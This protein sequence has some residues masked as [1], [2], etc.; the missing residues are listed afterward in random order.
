MA[1]VIIAIIVFLFSGAFALVMGQTPAGVKPTVVVGDV[2]TV[3]DKKFV[4]NWKTGPVDITT[5]DKTSF[6]KVSAESPNLATATPGAFTDIGVGDKLT[7]SGIMD[8]DGKTLP[9]RSVYFITKADIAAKNA[10]ESAEWQRRGITGKVTAV[11]AQTNQ[12]TLETRTLTGASNVVVTPKEGV[13]FFRYAP[14]SIRFDEAVASSLADTKVGDMVRALGDKSSDGL[15]FAAE[16]VVAGAFQTI[17]GTVKSIDT[18]KNEVII[19][20]LQTNKDVT[21]VISETSVLKRFPAEQAEMLARFQMMGAVG[22][23]ARPVG[24]PGQ[25]GQG[26]GARGTQPPAANPGGN[27]GGQGRP[28]MGGGRGPGGVED[29]LERSPNISAADLKVGDIIALSSTKTADVARI[30]AIKLF[31]G[32]EPFLRAAQATSGRGGRGGQGGV[33]GGFSIPGLDGIGF[34]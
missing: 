17:A 20:N 1:Q 3:G 11:N 10:K 14:D 22:G 19:K 9:A 28:G 26:G 12:M 24:Q 8:A 32:V 2:V 6:K 5:N 16:Q 23:G 18:A 7:V 13:K 29:M 21:I 27:P 25:G 31:A 15:S 34:P 30:K 4:V 33:D